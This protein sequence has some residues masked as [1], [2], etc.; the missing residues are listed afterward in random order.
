VRVGLTVL[1]CGLAIAAV[2]AGVAVRSGDDDGD[3]VARSYAQRDVDR[4]ARLAP[5]TPG[6]PAWP[7]KPDEK[8]PSTET[9][10]EAAAKDPVYAEYRRKTAR[11]T[12]DTADAGNHWMDGQKLANLSLGA[13]ASAADAHEVFV[14]SNELSLDYGKQYGSVTKAQPVPGLGDEAWRLWAQGNGAQVTYHWRRDN[15][16]VEVHI[17]C[18]GVCPADV[19]GATRA[20]ADA[21]D[22]AARAGR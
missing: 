1:A 21:I 3:D 4:L 17:H 14:A 5:V 8:R 2:A 13:L 20:W 22:A 7:E 11:L 10:E 18:F 16:V 19:D 6:W 15:L 9:P 12:G